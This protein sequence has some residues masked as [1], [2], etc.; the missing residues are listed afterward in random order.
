MVRGIRSDKVIN[1][2]D[3]IPHIKKSP[4]GKIWVEWY[5]HDSNLKWEEAAQAEMQVAK[6][7]VVDGF[8]EMARQYNVR[9]AREVA[10][11]NLDQTTLA[12]GSGSQPS[13]SL[14]MGPSLIRERTRPATDYNTPSR[15][16]LNADLNFQSSGLRALATPPDS[17]SS[18]LTLPTPDTSFSMLSLNSPSE[19][20]PGLRGLPTPDPSSSLRGLPTPDL[21][22]SLS[23]GRVRRPSDVSSLTSDHSADTPGS[24]RSRISLPLMVPIHRDNTGFHSDDTG[25]GHYIGS[26]PLLSLSSP[27]RAPPDFDL[28]FALYQQEQQEAEA[29]EAAAAA[30]GAR[31]PIG[32]GRNLASS[33]R[34][35]SSSL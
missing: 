22:S 33:G 21:S 13:P 25:L 34:N 19:P 7:L 14:P 17:S 31:L 29:E 23:A 11:R 32:S 10:L 16:P 24:V 28:E 20:S 3:R 15:Q 35:L 30:Q 6:T 12:Q 18:A 4:Y 9:E 1:A 27:T 2:H 26:G 5:F 8:H